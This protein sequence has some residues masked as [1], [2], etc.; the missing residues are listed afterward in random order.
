[1]RRPVLRGPRQHRQVDDLRVQLTEVL[2]GA[3]DHEVRVVRVHDLGDGHAPLGELGARVVVPVPR[4][5][6]VQVE[7]LVVLLVDDALGLSVRAGLLADAEGEVGRVGPPLVP[8]LLLVLEL[9]GALGPHELAVHDEVVGGQHHLEVERV[10]EHADEDAVDEVG[11][12]REGHDLVPVHVV[13]GTQVSVID[14]DRHRVD[15]AE[16]QPDGQRDGEGVEVD[17]RQLSGQDASVHRGTSG[18][19]GS[20]F[21]PT[22]SYRESRAACRYA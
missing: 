1:M 16:A 21:V 4:H 15:L 9:L 20:G 2:D 5:A 17:R 11:V 3:G 22:Y 13:V 8:P 14:E 18:F 6:Q 10:L 12:G 7:D 19:S